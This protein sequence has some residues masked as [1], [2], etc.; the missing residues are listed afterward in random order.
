MKNLEQILQKLPYYFSKE[1]ITKFVDS[2][3]VPLLGQYSNE[4]LNNYLKEQTTTSES[5][6]LPNLLTFKTYNDQLYYITKAKVLP[7]ILR[8]CADARDTVKSNISKDWFAIYKRFET[9]PEMSDSKAFE[10]RLEQEVKLCSP[11]LYALLNSNFL[12]L[13][14]LPTEQFYLTANF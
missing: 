4:D 11:V 12:K 10:K 1:A 2:K 13:T 6:E 14:Y 9:V 3:G 5:N 8:L 7:L